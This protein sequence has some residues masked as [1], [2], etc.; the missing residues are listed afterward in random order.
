MS[1]QP[2]NGNYNGQP[3]YDMLD[4]SA[5]PT[6]QGTVAAVP[7]GAP[8]PAIVSTGGNNAQSSPPSK[9]EV[10]WYFVEQYYTTLSRSPEKIHVR[11]RSRWN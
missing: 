5:A 4:P 2:V 3:S 7:N 11:F 6:T 10:G 8:A 1:A 9:D